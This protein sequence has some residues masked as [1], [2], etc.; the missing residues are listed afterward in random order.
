MTQ[1]RRPGWRE[2]ASGY[3]SDILGPAGQATAGNPPQ[4]ARPG[5]RDAVAGPGRHRGKQP[6]MSGPGA[7]LAVPADQAESALQAAREAWGPEW[8]WWLSETGFQPPPEAEL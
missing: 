6:A 1:A 8:P 7:D 4:T 5:A 2:L 3:R